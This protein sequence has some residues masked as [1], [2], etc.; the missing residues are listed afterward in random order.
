MKENGQMTR[1]MEKE[2]KLIKMEINM[3]KNGLMVKEKTKS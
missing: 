1:D 3:M 2:C